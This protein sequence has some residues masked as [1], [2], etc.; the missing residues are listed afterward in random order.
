MNG[1]INYFPLMHIVNKL[2][3]TV[4]FFSITFRCL[5]FISLSITTAANANN[6]TLDDER[7]LVDKS[8]VT[9]VFYL[10]SEGQNLFLSALGISIYHVDDLSAEMDS[11]LS[12]WHVSQY[13]EYFHFKNV[14][15]GYYLSGNGEPSLSDHVQLVP[16]VLDD[17]LTLWIIRREGDGFDVINKQTGLSLQ[18]SVQATIPASIHATELESKAQYNEHFVFLPTEEKTTHMPIVVTSN[19]S[20][21]KERSLSSVN[22]SMTTPF[23]NDLNFIMY[24]SMNDTTTKKNT[25][26]STL[27]GDIST[28]WSGTGNNPWVEYDLGVVVTLDHINVAFFNDGNRPSAFEIQLSNN[29]MYWN[30]AV[31]GIS[32]LGEEGLRRVDIPLSAA[33]FVRIVGLDIGND[34]VFALSEVVF[35]TISVPTTGVAGL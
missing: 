32:P 8:A 3:L 35:D 27:D 23:H 6:T 12:K 24:S 5:L 15:S 14:A 19:T 10:Q 2:K 11:A 7:H 4:F 18:A 30:T 26:Q 21:A 13:G 31:E 1:I 33:R 20:K 29:G 17:P 28:R 25:A 16:R 34:Q 9:G 22:K